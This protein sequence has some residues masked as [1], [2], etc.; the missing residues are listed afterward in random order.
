ME[1]LC[2]LLFAIDY[3]FRGLYLADRRLEYFFSLA[4][5][6]NLLVILPILPTTFYISY[7]YVFYFV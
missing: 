7:Q 1:I 5:L 2:A 4:G 6:V 3:L